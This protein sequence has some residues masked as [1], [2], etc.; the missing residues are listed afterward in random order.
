MNH[1]ARILPRDLP[2]CQVPGGKCDAIKV[3]SGDTS[4]WFAGHRPDSALSICTGCCPL[5]S[6]PD[7]R[8]TLSADSG[9]TAAFDKD[10]LL[11]M[12][13]PLRMQGK[14]KERIREILAALREDGAKDFGALSS[15][16][17]VRMERPQSVRKS[18][19]RMFFRQSPVKNEKTAARPQ[20]FCLQRAFSSLAEGQNPPGCKQV[21]K[22]LFPAG[23][24]PA[25]T[26]AS[27][28]AVFLPFC[29]FLPGSSFRAVQGDAP[30]PS[31]LLS[32]SPV[33]GS[34]GALIWRFRSERAGKSGVLCPEGS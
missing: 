33:K 8:A 32:P 25:R 34:K 11:W 1:D 14:E 28:K 6:D 5:Y 15:K 13:D 29:L 18:P 10:F 2:I 22:N 12:M 19:F 26:G 3:L 4:T 17:A 24:L 21:Q 7:R 31:R 9:N 16:G 30:V 27:G 23:T 20:L